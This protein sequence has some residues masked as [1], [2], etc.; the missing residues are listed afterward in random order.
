MRKLKIGTIVKTNS[1]IG[2]DYWK[3]VLRVTKSMWRKQGI[4]CDKPGLYLF[5]GMWYGDNP[6]DSNSFGKIE[7]IP[8]RYLYLGEVNSFPVE[9]LQRHMR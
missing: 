9:E 7:Y 2:T 8:A 5:Y 3:I 4:N 6:L 1:D